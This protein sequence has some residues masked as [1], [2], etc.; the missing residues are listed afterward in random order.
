[1][2]GSIVITG[3]SSGIGAALARYYAGPNRRIVL[4]GRSVERLHR[5]AQ[6]C[7]AAGA[8]AEVHALDVRDRAG[9]TKCLLAL[10]REAPIGLL[11]ANA[12]ILTGTSPA[13]IPENLEDAAELVDINVVGIMNTVLP[14]L[15]M[16]QGRQGGRIAIMSSLAAI[17][18]LPDA[19]AYSAS[20][21]ALLAYGLALRDQ[22]KHSGVK[23]NVVCPGY[24]T[25]Q[26]SARESG[27][28]PFEITA[29]AAAQRIAR[30]LERDAP[31]IAFPLP[32]VW[33]ARSAPYVPEIVRSFCISRFRMTVTD[34]PD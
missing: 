17:A 28:H 30:G 2:S 33:L 19:P 12:G 1:M 16:M 7:S 26:M 5:I 13:G 27:W 14:V 4:M 8:S 29:E 10:D 11:I 22:V 23:V 31:V 15:P 34:E 20:K 24:V 32:L 21:A 25:T 3:A 18:P 9:M 6:T